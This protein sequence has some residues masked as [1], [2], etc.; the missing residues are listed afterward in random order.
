MQFGRRAGWP[1]IALAAFTLVALLR[2]AG[3]LDSFERHVADERARFLKH[4]VASDVVIIGIDA[5]SLAELRQWPWP[6]RHHAALIERLAQAE[7]RR[8]FLDIDFSSPSSAADDALLEDALARWPHT[9]IVLPAFFQP[10]SGADSQIV[11][12]E[13]LERL[14]GHA[15]LASVNLRPGS[16]GLVRTIHGAWRLGDRILPSVIA[17]EGAGAANTTR[18][19]PI[20]FSISPA[21]FT[22]FSYSDVLAGRVAPAEFNGKSVFVGATAVELGDMVPVPVY[23]SMPGVALL[24]LASQTVA[25]G[26][27]WSPPGWLYLLSIAIL[28]AACAALFDRFSWRM[29]LAVLAGLVLAICAVSLYAYAV[30]QVV[31]DVMPAALAALLAFGMV[32]LKSLDVQTLRAL[33]FA[34][35][36]RRRNALLRS[37]VESAAEGILGIDRR[38]AIQTVNPAAARLFGYDA[39]A[40]IGTPITRLFPSLPALDAESLEALSGSVSEHDALSSAGASFPAE[41]SVSRVRLKDEILYTAIVRDISE[42][43]EQQRG[44]EYRA[45]HDPLTS[46]PNRAE[47][48]AHLERALGSVAPGEAVALLM[49]DLCRFKEV[50]DTLGHDVGDRVLCEVAFRFQAVLAKCGLVARIGGDEFTVVLEGPCDPAQ[51]ASVC[52]RLHECLRKPIEVRGVAIDVGL[53]IGIALYPQH[54]AD[55][56]TLLRHA[57][58]AMYVAKRRG[59]AFEH[60]EAAYDQHSIRKLTMVSELRTALAG[61]HLNLYFQPQVNLHT[62]RAASVEA[63]LRWRHPRLGAVSPAEFIAAAEPTD[64]IEPLTEWTLREALAQTARWG[65]M[66]LTLRAAVNLSARMLQ[67]PDFPARLRTLLQESGVDPRSLELEIT[68]SAMLHDPARALDVIRRIHELEVQISIDDFGT[69]YSSLGYLRDLPVHALKLDKSFVIS[70]HERADDRAIVESTAQMARALRLQVVAEGVE[71]EWHARFLAGAGYDLA[72]GYWYSAALSAADC[73]RWITDFNSGTAAAR[74]SDD[75]DDNTRARRAHL[76]IAR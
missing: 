29:N 32:T 70:M 54:A 44:L 27:P 12:T 63:L 31:L 18:E 57:D 8:L 36:L 39:A 4:E 34:V 24:A 46:L 10:A 64:L 48:A 58:V 50:N 15:A 14:A 51:T 35:R 9:P 75:G 65:R 55:A 33:F 3:V 19:L 16:D 69:G 1:L 68:E 61:E 45:T 52:A 38:G 71:T 67:N 62:G 66:G 60:Y 7:P 28:T 43:K 21:S 40:L 56:E 37:I 53:S 6:R 25:S 2:A 74:D 13:P 41:V 22:F 11:L 23:R 17:P 20:D 73:T 42:R 76:K 26:L 49:L 59:T 5:R 47:L 72:Q 30:R